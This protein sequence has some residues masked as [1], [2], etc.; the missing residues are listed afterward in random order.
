VRW[1][2]LSV[3]ADVEAIEA[4]SE[5]FG[6]LGRGAAVRPTRLVHDPG[7]ELSAREDTSAPYELTVHIPDDGAAAGAVEETERALWHLQAFGL[8]PVGALQVTPVEE[9]DWTEAWKAGYTPQRIGRIVVMPSWLDEPIGPGEVLLRLDPGMAF[10]TGLHPTTR[11]CLRLTQQL[12]PM[13]SAVLDVGS[14]SGILALAALKLGAR[15]AV[16]LDT[17]AAAVEATRANAAANGLEGRLEARHGTLPAEPTA[18]FPLV[19]A[20]LVAGLLVELAPRLAAHAEPGATLLAG[21]IID[22]R[23]GEVIEALAAAGL[24]VRDRIDE[25]EWVSLR[26]ERA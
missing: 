20:N 14:G 23:A 24:V 9:A 12:R 26:L 16:C 5:V 25:D 18:R 8:R 21:G 2:A 7:D 1:L 17:D 19:V 13:P 22:H 3:E 6:R 11:G 15:S 10:G 4:V